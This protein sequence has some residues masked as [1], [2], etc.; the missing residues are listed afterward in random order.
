MKTQFFKFLKTPCALPAGV[1][2]LACIS[3]V[4]II[5]ISALAQQD[6]AAA[7]QQMTTNLDERIKDLNEAKTCVSAAQDHTALKKCRKNL[8][9][10]HMEM[11]EKNMMKHHHGHMDKDEAGK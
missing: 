7:K 4:V 9:E 8:R 2:Y 11:R 6:F 10:E 1:A 3:S 5:S